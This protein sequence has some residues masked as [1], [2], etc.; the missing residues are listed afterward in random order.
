METTKLFV[1]ASK[2]H[3]RYPYKGNISTEDLWD[4]DI[5]ALDEVYKNLRKIL[6]SM[7]DEESLLNTSDNE[8]A[9]IVNDKIEIVKY[10]LDSKLK[11]IDRRKAEMANAVARQ[12]I[13][14]LIASKKNEA[15]SNLSVEELEAKLKELA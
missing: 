4:L 12:Q 2:K 3:Y 1:L 10:I 7:G 11:E 6:K 13:M 8:A 5:H 9:I 15:L 14:E